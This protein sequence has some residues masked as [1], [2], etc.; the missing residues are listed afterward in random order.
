M[1]TGP[2][3]DWVFGQFQ[4]PTPPLA[5]Q[6]EET[7]EAHRAFIA[8]RRSLPPAE[9]YRTPIDAEWEDFL[10][11]F[12][13]RKLSVGTCARAYGTDCIHEHACLSCA[14]IPPSAVGWWK[15][16]TTS[17]TESGRRKERAG[18]ARS[19]G[20]ASAWPAPSPRSARLTPRPLD[21]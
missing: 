12:E 8:R 14:P 3:T 10:G 16:G 18:S 5:I 7:I 19:K 15:S 13:R 20:S 6:P 1:P 4:Y 2:C 9:E 17:L 11:H 21:E